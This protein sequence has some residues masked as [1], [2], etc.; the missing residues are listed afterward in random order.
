MLAYC[1][2]IWRCRYFWL[3]LV[4]LDLRSRYRGSVLGLGW[5]LVH[6]LAMTA[7]FFAIFCKL[8]DQPPDYYT[9]NVL[10]GM[11]CWTFLVNTTLIGC[12]CFSQAEVY[13]RQHPAPMAI[14]PL[15]VVL[16]NLFH[17]L[18]AL[19]LALILSMILLGRCNMRSL[20]GLPATLVLMLLL[21]WSLAV[22]GGLAHVYFR[23]TRHLSEIGFQV[24]F[25]MTPVFYPAEMLETR[26]LGMLLQCNPLLP[27]L[28]L[29]R[30]AI[31]EGEVPSAQLYLKACAIVV[32]AVLTASFALGRLERRLIFYL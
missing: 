6:P 11:A 22:L 17:C 16:G 25:Y 9:V 27:F 21:G 3:S 20:L 30:M 8:F 12:N 29:F 7:I 14:Y 19:L 4:K 23:D 24:L 13:I 31:V 15:R 10:T 5:S 1:S 2:A 18:I 28:K 26:G 32:A